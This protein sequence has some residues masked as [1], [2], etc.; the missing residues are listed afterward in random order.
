VRVSYT[1]EDSQT[2][3]ALA[4]QTKRVMEGNPHA[5]EVRVDW[6]QPAR[7]LE[8]VVASV[9]AEAAGIDPAEIAR[10]IH[11]FTQGRTVGVYR[12]GDKLI[13]IVVRPPAA[14]RQ[15]LDDLYQQPIW[16][17]AAGRMIPLRQVLS[18]VDPGWEDGIIRRKNRKR[19]LEVLCDPVSGTAEGL[20]RQLAPGIAG[21]KLPPGYSMAWTGE[22]KDSKEANES[23]FA[24]VPLAFLGMV[25]IVVVLFNAFRQP[26][27]IFLCLPLALIGVTAG[28]LLTGLPLSFMA[29]LGIL[30]LSG[31][32]I[33]NAVVLID[34]IDLDIA[35]GKPKLRAIKDASI[36]RLRP[37]LM[38]AI[39]TVLGMAPLIIDPFYQSMAVTIM[40]GLTF[41]TLL[42]LLV[43]PVLYALFF[44]AGHT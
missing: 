15:D 12:E 2:L 37:V 25:L 11:R 14:D 4:D 20:R 40:F 3:R 31:M 29:V 13:P 23:V 6:R 21:I 9:P 19:T 42:T 10:A 26:L 43:V 5:K 32:L 17:P 38:A 16:S 30:S 1:G 28:L 34:Q 18:G 36:S 22:Y 35:A 39:T 27:I 7:L 33:K 24:G 41:A 44:R 8:P